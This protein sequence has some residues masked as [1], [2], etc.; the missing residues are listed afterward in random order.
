MV[1]VNFDG[2]VGPTHHYGGHSYGNLASMEHKQKISNPKAAALQGLRKMKLLMDLGQAQAVIP[3]QERP[4]LFY[5][6]QLGFTGTD[7]DVVTKAAKASPPLFYAFCSSSAM[8]TA[9]AAT[10]SPSSDTPDGKLHISIAN[11]QTDL[12]RSIESETTYRLFQLLFPQ[13]VVHPPLPKGGKFGDEGAANHTRLSSGVHIFVYGSSAFSKEK[14]LFPAR[15]SQEASEAIA[16]RHGVKNPIILQQNPKA[17]DAGVFHNDVI[18]TG[19]NHLYLY[20]EHAYVDDALLESLKPLKV[21][22]SMLPLKK[23][24]SSYLFNSQII[25]DDSGDLVLIAPEECRSLNLDW[26]PINKRHFIDLRESM[27]NGGGPA[28]LRLRIEMTN[29]EISKSH[30][31]IFLTPALYEALVKWVE[32]YYRDKL[33]LKDLED[34]QLLKECQDALSQLSNL[35]KINKLYKF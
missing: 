18:A 19:H 17:I 20:H 24:V 15:Q 2:L 33:T 16:R 13:A 6:R 23:A 4:S 12:H 21:K 5:L 22:E 35:L 3:P 8:W 34:P 25:T 26:L 30:T 1:E 9:N 11:L 31:P 32:Q 27:C 29:D 28:C 10:I 7:A 14:T